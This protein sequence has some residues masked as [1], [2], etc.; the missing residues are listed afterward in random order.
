MKEEA[1]RDRS[2]PAIA[3]QDGGSASLSTRPFRSV[4]NNVRERS[5]NEEL[6][7]KISGCFRTLQGAEDF[8]IIRSI[9]DTARK[10]GLDVMEVLAGTPEEFLAAIGIELPDWWGTID[11]KKQGII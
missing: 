11:E 10:N 2:R 8:A 7:M 3:E 6:L 4:A 1:P 9:I 5:S